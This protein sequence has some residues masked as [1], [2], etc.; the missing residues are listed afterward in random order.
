M[1]EAVAPLLDLRSLGGQL[2]GLGSVPQPPGRIDVPC[3]IAG[4]V[5]TVATAL[6]TDAAQTSREL[7]ARRFQDDM[8]QRRAAGVPAGLIRRSVAHGRRV[9]DALTAWIERDGHSSIVGRSYTPPLG[10]DKWEST[11]PN[12]G[13]A[14][15]PY[16]ADVR[17]MVLREAG[18]V[19]PQEHVPYSEEAGSEFWHQAQLTYET[20]L[21]LTDEQRAIARF[22]TDNPL[23]SGLPS[24]HWMLTVSQ[25]S[26]QQHLPL[27]TVLEAYATLGVALHDAFLNCWTWKYRYNLLRPVTY[28]RRFIDP[29]WNTFVNTPQFP[30]F[31]SGHSVASRAASTVLT[32]L[33]GNIAYV[34]DSHAPRNMPARHFNSFTHA[35]D[36]AAQS[37]L[38]GGIHYAMGIERG[39]LQGDDV[40]ALV[41]DRLHTRR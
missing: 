12:Y 15:E 22:W 37:R 11:P 28:V 19:S 32:E 34:D 40:G 31:T 35:A 20:G 4:S 1:Y 30:E 27:R 2:A 41:L 6:F 9:G 14:I 17:P 33:L 21:A 7:L 24:G 10:P 8:A 26:R 23:L 29:T 39:K 38:Y 16:W 18:E 36:E 5:A 13:R 3:A 25:F